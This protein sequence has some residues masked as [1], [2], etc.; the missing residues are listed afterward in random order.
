MIPSHSVRD[1]QKSSKRIKP[2]RNSESTRISQE[3]PHPQKGPRI[4]NDSSSMPILK[5]NSCV[6]NVHCYLWSKS[7]G[8]LI[9]PDDNWVRSVGGRA[10]TNR[11]AFVGTLKS[12]KSTGDEDKGEEENKQK[13]SP[14]QASIAQIS[15]CTFDLH[16]IQESCCCWYSDPSHARWDVD[17]HCELATPLQQLLP[18]PIL[19]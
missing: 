9:P 10:H 15:R 1:P 3:T 6:Q 11:W 7:W 14:E 12:D 17:L 13:H 2:F 8:F 5:S 16:R 18:H 19:H 4:A